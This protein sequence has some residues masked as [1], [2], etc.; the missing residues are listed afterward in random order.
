ME[1][2][3]WWQIEGQSLAFAVREAGYD[4]TM[5]YDYPPDVQESLKKAAIAN[6]MSNLIY[7]FEEKYS[8]PLPDIKKGVYVIGLSDPFTIAY[9]EWSSETIYI[10]QGNIV[11]RLETHF[12]N[13]LFKVMMSLAGADF[14]FYLSE[15]VHG[16]GADF[17]KHVEHMLLEKFKQKSGGSFPL[18]NEKAGSKRNYDSLPKGWDTPLKM[19]GKKPIWAISPTKFWNFAKLD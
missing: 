10:G 9:G 8:K 18:L 6:V 7:D 2:M 1:N 12:K 3:K 16:E 4:L 13:S 17:H 15:P 14:K 5:F 19:S 11:N